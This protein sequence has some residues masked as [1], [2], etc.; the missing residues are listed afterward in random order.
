MLTD[1]QREYL[2]NHRLA[3]LATG[4]R[5]GSPQQSMIGYAF[6]GENIDIS[7]GRDRAKWRN[8]SRQ[9]RVSLLVPDGRRQLIIYGTARLLDADPERID[10]AV[11]LFSSF[12]GEEVDRDEVARRYDEENRG[13]IRVAADKAFLND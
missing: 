12:R 1:D 8:I 4:R 13:V 7:C 6:D 9:P 10:A 2:S 3:I 11:A 5:D